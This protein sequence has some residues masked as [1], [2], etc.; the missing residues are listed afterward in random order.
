MKCL[1]ENSECQSE[2]SME[3]MSDKC[4]VTKEVM[5]ES[6]YKLPPIKKVP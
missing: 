1:I 4:R 5:L 3:G 6:T 2:F